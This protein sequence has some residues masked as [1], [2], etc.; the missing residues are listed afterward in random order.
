MFAEEG[1]RRKRLAGRVNRRCHAQR[2]RDEREHREAEDALE[3]NDKQRREVPAADELLLHDLREA[4]TWAVR[5]AWSQTR[6]GAAAPPHHLRRHDDLGE[7]DDGV[8]RGDAE[9]EEEERESKRGGGRGVSGKESKRG[10]GRGV[11]GMPR[12]SGASDSP[13]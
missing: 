10:G 7:D 9:E 5:V 8:L 13:P 4:Y 3:A 2:N 12:T 1:G 6:A 11:S